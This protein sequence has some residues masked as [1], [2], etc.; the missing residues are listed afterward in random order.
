LLE[1]LDFVGRAITGEHDLF[2]R[3]VQGIERVKEFL[4]NALLAGQ[5]LDVTWRYFLRNLMSTLFCS[6]SMYSLVNFSEDR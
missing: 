3:L 1:S 6:A 4:L 5:E 2:V